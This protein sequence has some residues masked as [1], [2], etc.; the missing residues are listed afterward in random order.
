MSTPNTVLTQLRELI[1][2]SEAKTGQNY[3]NLY[4]AVNGLI[5]GYA[6]IKE[7][8]VSNQNGTHTRTVACETC[9]NILET[10]EDCADSDVDSVCDICGG[11]MCKHSNYTIE[12]IGDNSGSHIVRKICS[13]CGVIFSEILEECSSTTPSIVRI[14]APGYH[15]MAS[16]CKY[17]RQ[18]TFYE[19]VQCTDTNGD[20]VCDKC[21]D[22]V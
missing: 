8:V 2:A 15:A 13:D 1:D 5:S 11:A 4:D 20:G 16:H 9:G 3:D 21:G 22:A 6:S 18:E 12:Y 7:T 17:C 10:I 19:R 14:A